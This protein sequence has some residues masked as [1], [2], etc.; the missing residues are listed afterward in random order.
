MLAIVVLE[1]V[2]YK[3]VNKLDKLREELGGRLGTVEEKVDKLSYFAERDEKYRLLRLVPP[4]KRPLFYP[5]QKTYRPGIDKLND[6]RAELRRNIKSWIALDEDLLGRETWLKTIETETID[7]LGVVREKVEFGFRDNDNWTLRGYLLYP[8]STTGNSRLPGIICLNG[9]QGSACN[10]AGFEDD[11]THSY[12]LALAA[13]GA[14]V[15]TF[16]WCFEGQSS[17]TDESGNSYNGHTSIFDYMAATGQKGLALYMENA[18]CA[19]KVL[20]NDPA[21]D[22]SRVGISGISRGGELTTYFAALFAPQINAYY[23]SGAGFPFSYRKFGGGCKCTYVDKILDN[24][25][26]SDLLVA[27][28]PVPG[29]LQ[30]GLNDKILGYM[31]NLENLLTVTMPV[32]KS[33]GVPGDFGVDLH[34]AGHEYRAQ[35][36]IPFFRTYLGL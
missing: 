26:F 10:V 24:Y 7:S 23:A 30:M 18:C 14:K 20:K 21:V 36:A 1:I 3:F 19:L 17:L 2:N 34:E 16:D 35:Q 5:A 8:S 13:E 11:Y 32:Y 31:D 27:A 33:L 12:G 4:Q 9:H 22:S 15:L 28:A 6:F 25:E 29:H